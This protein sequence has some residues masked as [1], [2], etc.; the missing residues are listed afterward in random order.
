MLYAEVIGQI[1]DGIECAVQ[2]L[3]IKLFIIKELVVKFTLYYM[4][5]KQSMTYAI[6]GQ[7]K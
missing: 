1:I 6:L 3:T 4:K 5:Y 2:E 7:L